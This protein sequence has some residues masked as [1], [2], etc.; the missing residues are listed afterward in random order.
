VNCNSG[1]WAVSPVS[2]VRSGTQLT[3]NWSAPADH[4]GTAWI[5]VAKEGLDSAEAGRSDWKRAQAG[6][7]GEVQMAAPATP[8]VYYAYIFPDNGYGVV[9][10]PTRL[11]VD[12]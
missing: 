4:Q 8:G 3:V 2:P 9:G 5:G 11:V 6:P 7:C 12:P 10:G 1:Q